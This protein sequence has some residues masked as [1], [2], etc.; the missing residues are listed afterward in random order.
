M[1]ELEQPTFRS[2]SKAAQAVLDGRP[3][4]SRCA[5]QTGLMDEDGNFD[6]SPIQGA[7]HMDQVLRELDLKRVLMLDEV[8]LAP[9]WADL[10]ARWAQRPPGE[11]A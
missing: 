5:W 11:Q 3:H 2:G 1:A 8:P 4:A 10:M 7:K 9:L 6:F